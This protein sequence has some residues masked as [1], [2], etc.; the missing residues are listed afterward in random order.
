[1]LFDLSDRLKLRLTGSDRV[2]FLNGQVTNDIRKANANLSLP[3]CVLNAKG[4]TDAFLFVSAGPDDLFLDADAELRESLAPRLE[5]YLIADDVTVED[6]TEEFS[7]FHVIGA[8]A[9]TEPGGWRR[10]RR[11]GAAGWDLVVPRADH[12]R[13]LQLLASRYSLGKASEAERRRIEQGVPRW[14]RELTDQ[15]IP[16]E[17]NLADEA[18]DYAKGCYIG[19]E[20]ISRMK[21]SGQTNKRLC[22]LISRDGTTLTKGMRLFTASVVGGDDPGKE[23][24]WITS[25]TRSERLGQEIALGYVKRGANETG[26]ALSARMPDDGNNPVAVEV[27][28]L[29]FG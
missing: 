12:D 5:R 15:I 3:A 13:V 29:P 14:G 9:P 2:R 17:A 28:A 19:Q 8:S 22:G 24:G 23:V 26:T 7:L 20:V 21:M 25:A 1:M 16:V 11:F 18:V 6:V 4:K 10:A 27:V